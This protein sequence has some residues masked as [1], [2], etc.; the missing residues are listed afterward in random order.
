MADKDGNPLDWFSGDGKAFVIRKGKD[1][2]A[3]TKVPDNTNVTVT[4][5]GKPMRARRSAE[6]IENADEYE[7]D[8]YE[9][10]GDE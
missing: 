6:E 3:D 4:F 2:A 10:E 9:D 1:G 5:S 8:E 7:G